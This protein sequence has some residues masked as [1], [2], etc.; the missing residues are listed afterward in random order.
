MDVEVAAITDELPRGPKTCPRLVYDKPARSS[1]GIRGG[2]NG[3]GGATAEAGTS[4]DSLSN[5]TDTRHAAHKKTRKRR[6]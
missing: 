4:T 1:H 5:R 2:A 3:R 6:R